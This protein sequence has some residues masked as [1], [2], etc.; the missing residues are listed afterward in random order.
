MIIPTTHGDMEDTDLVLN[1]EK[2]DN[3]VELT[4]VIEYWLVSDE[5]CLDPAHDVS[6]EQPNGRWAE[7]VHRSV[8][9][10]L[11]QPMAE[12]TSAVGGVG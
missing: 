6:V 9:M 3:A 11:K 7:R 8:R 4:N 10:V 5:K 1:T 12:S 2:T